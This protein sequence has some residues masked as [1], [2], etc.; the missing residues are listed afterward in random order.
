MSVTV[1]GPSMEEPGGM[2]AITRELEFCDYSPNILDKWVILKYSQ[3]IQ[4]D[5][6]DLR[7]IYLDRS[8]ELQVTLRY[9]GIHND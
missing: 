9:S 3:P 8:T 1:C 6:F 5:S 7:Y 2:S 4:G